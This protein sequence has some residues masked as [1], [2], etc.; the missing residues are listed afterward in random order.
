L[1]PYTHPTVDKVLPKAPGARH[2][3]SAPSLVVPAIDAF[4]APSIIPEIDVRVPMNAESQTETELPPRISLFKDKVEPK[5][6]SSE[7]EH[8]FCTRVPP[9]TDIVDPNVTTPITEIAFETPTNESVTENDPP[10]TPGPEIDISPPPK[11]REHMETDDPSTVF[12]VV[13]VVPSTTVVP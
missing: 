8:K 12:D 6:T 2:E 4:D 7:I 9:R 13:D 5:W 1:A 11:T 10:S 3:K